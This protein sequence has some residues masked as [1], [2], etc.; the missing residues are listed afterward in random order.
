MAHSEQSSIAATGV[1]V[2]EVLLS[3]R[4]WKRQFS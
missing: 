4:A 3:I 2:G 1:M